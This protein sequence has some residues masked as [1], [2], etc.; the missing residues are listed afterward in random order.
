VSWR[1]NAQQAFYD[2]A[3]GDWTVTGL[4][5]ALDWDNEQ[6]QRLWSGSAWAQ[7]VMLTWRNVLLTRQNV[8]LT[9]QNVQL[10]GHFPWFVLAAPGCR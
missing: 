4:A 8:M 5:Q 7:N 9:W 10:M 3:C 2:C 6:L 1:H